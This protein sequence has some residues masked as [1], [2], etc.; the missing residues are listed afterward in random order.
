MVR[1]FPVTEIRVGKRHRRDHGD[2]K[3]LAKSIT[4]VGLLQPIAVTEDGELLFGE[5]RLRAVRDVLKQETILARVLNVADLVGCEA[6]ENLIRKDFTVTERV[7]IAQSVEASLGERRGGDHTKRQKIDGCRGQRSD[8]IAAKSAGFGN[9]ETYRQ[10]KTVVERGI[11][12]LVKAMDRGDVSISFAARIANEEHETQ[13]DLLDK[14]LQKP[15]EVEPKGVETGPASGDQP[16]PRRVKRVDPL[17]AISDRCE[18][19]DKRINAAFKVIAAPKGQMLPDIRARLQ[20]TVEALQRLHSA[21]A[22]LAC[23]DEP[24]SDH[25][26]ASPNGEADV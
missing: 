9:R 3:A 4:E 25:A 8:T 23:V 10:A 19:L 12:A 22:K 1:H 15:E 7:A 26:A 18:Q 14:A 2:I 13:L 5:R 6:A 20:A 11:A 24:E 21:I 16:V 17:Q